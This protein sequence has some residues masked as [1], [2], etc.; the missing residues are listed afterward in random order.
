[1][2]GSS[3]TT[4]STSAPPSQ[5]LNA[6]TDVYNQA[7]GLTTQPYQAY[8]GPMVAGFTPDQLAAFST[9]ENTQGLA[10]PYYDQAS[11][12]LMSSAM[13]IMPYTFDNVEI[14]D[15]LGLSYFDWAGQQ[16]QRAATPIELMEY[17][18]RPYESAYTEE[19]T[20]DLA[21][22]YNAQNAEQFNAARGN[23]AAQ[24]A[25]GGDRE[26]IMA[27]EMARQQKLAQDP[28]LAQIQQTGF[29]QAQE[30]FNKQ[31]AIDYQQQ[32]AERQFAMGAGQLGLGIGSGLWGEFNT[33][34]AQDVAAQQASAALQAQAAQGLASIGNM[35]QNSA[36]TRG[37]SATRRRAAAAAAGTAAA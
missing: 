12:Y 32:V 23:A 25:F 35:A 6:Y 10:Q 36:L 21:T 34:Q 15:D 31:Q 2:C 16:A 18:I 29:A 26:A 19:V 1:M 28:T 17:D 11:S 30:E 4:T 33:Q 8:T 22:L 5:F 37:A 27:A 24:G 7:A 13:P 14:L 3:A 9:I 20:N